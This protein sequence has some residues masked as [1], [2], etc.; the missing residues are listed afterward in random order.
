MPPEGGILPR[1]GAA[2]AVL[3]RLGREEK[4]K[5]EKFLLLVLCALGGLFNFLFKIIL[6]VQKKVV[7]LQR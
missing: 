2:S 5:N 3:Q 4:R 7:S 1:N 6:P